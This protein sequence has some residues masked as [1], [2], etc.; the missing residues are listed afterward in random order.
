MHFPILLSY[1]SMYYWK[2]ST[3][4]SL[5][6]VVMGLFMVTTTSKSFSW[7]SPQAEPDQVN[8]KVVYQC[9]SQLRTAGSDFQHT[10]FHYFCNVPKLLV[11]IFETL[12]FFMSSWLTVIQ[13]VNWRSLHTTCLNCFMLTSVL[14]FKASHSWSHLSPP[15]N[16]L[17]T[18]CTTLKH[19]CIHLQKHFKHLSFPH[20]DKKIQVYLFLGAEQ[21]EE[22]EA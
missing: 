9:F 10:Q 22:E 2:Y 17:W 7:W 16:P 21:Q 20:Y 12:S 3:G 14:L 18:S 6:S 5:N 11:I 15:Y 8:R 1:A 19:L 13:I 4:I